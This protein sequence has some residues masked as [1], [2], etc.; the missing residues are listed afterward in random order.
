MALQLIDKDQLSRSY[1][2]NPSSKAMAPHPLHPSHLLQTPRSVE[3]ATSLQGPRPMELPRPVKPPVAPVIAVHSVAPVKI[4]RPI[5]TTEQLRLPSGPPSIQFI[6]KKPA[7]KI[8]LRQSIIKLPLITPLNRI[9]LTKRIPNSLDTPII[10]TNNINNTNNTTNSNNINNIHNSIK[11]ENIIL[12]NDINFTN[13]V[14]VKLYYGLANRIFMVLA[15]LGYAERNNMNVVLCK[16]FIKDGIIDHEK[17]LDSFLLNI[18]PNLT[19]VDE[20][21]SYT[22]IN[23]D[24]GI[25]YHELPS[26]KGNIVLEGLF[27]SELYF[28]SRLPIF[29]VSKYKDTF[30]IHIRAGYYLTTHLLNIDLSNYYETCFNILGSN[31]KYILFSNDT[32]YA[33]DYMKKYSIS[34]TLAPDLNQY[35]TLKEMAS[36]SGGICANSTFSWMG[37]LFQGAQR[38]PIFM[39]SKWYNNV[40]YEDVYP[41][42]ASRVTINKIKE[43]DEYFAN[44][45]PGST[46]WITI[47]NNGYIEFTKNFIKSMDIYNSHFTLIVYCLD[48]EAL[49]QLKGIPNIIAFDASVFTKESLNSSFS[50]WGNSEYKK[51]CFSKLDAIK[52]T[53]QKCKNVTVG[54]IDTDI[55][56]LKNPTQTVETIMKENQDISIIAQCD[57]KHRCSNIYKCHSICAGL[58]IFKNTIDVLLLFEYKMSEIEKYSSDQDY[59]QLQIAKS[60]LK[61]LTVSKD[62]FLNGAYPGINDDTKL[63]IPDSA[64]LIHYN[65]IIG[66]AKIGCMKKNKM[67]FNQI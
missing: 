59:L 33:I 53:L 42:W 40:F 18:F 50:E 25:R 4:H 31:V 64:E 58:I 20:F 13:T 14:S 38:G 22:L 49:V 17:N 28:P 47:I 10:K 9:V 66:K 6:Q 23:N 48:L 41:S 45:K 24:D 32:A 16:S 3:L 52:Y 56:V 60:K 12:S 67:W 46:I 21:S 51:I 7:E 5:S 57:E 15:S 36:C 62:I 27:Q 35:D 63:I 2:R 55:I 44:I 29:N 61:Y 34:Y 43:Q 26:C 39:P 8:E 65:Y 37:A 54:Y 19:I 1:L 30:F 11:I